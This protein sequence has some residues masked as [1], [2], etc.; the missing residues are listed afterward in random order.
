MKD[1][2]APLS[3]RNRSLLFFFFFLPPFMSDTVTSKEESRA[4]ERGEK[5]RLWDG[6]RCRETLRPST[7][8][9]INTS[10]CD[11]ASGSSYHHVPL[12]LR[13]KET[14]F[15]SASLVFRFTCGSE[16]TYD[17]F[18]SQCGSC[19]SLPSVKKKKSKTP[20]LSSEELYIM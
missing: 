17:S 2:N 6:G 3:P 16:N 8:A 13:L 12:I 19:D 4:Q 14:C 1:T 7:A 11:A 18:S 20:P 15:L 9:V 5:C 10:L